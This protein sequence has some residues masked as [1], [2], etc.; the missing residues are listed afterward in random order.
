MKSGP[1]AKRLVWQGCYDQQWGGLITKDAYG[2]PAKFARGLIERIYDHCLERGWLQPGDVVGDPF[3]GVALGGIVAAYRKLRWLGVEIEPRFMGLADG[4]ECPGNRH[5]Q[6]WA[7]GAALPEWPVCHGCAADWKRG[8]ARAGH[9]AMGNLERHQDP[10]RVMGRAQPRQVMGDSRRFARIVGTMDLGGKHGR[11]PLELDG[12]TMS[13][14]Y[15]G[16][17]SALGVHNGIDYAKARQGGKKV[18]AGRRA[19]GEHYGAAKGQIGRLRTGRHVAGIVT[20]PP[21]EDQEGALAG[22]KFKF[23]PAVG[24]GHWTSPEARVAQLERGESQTYGK[25]PRQIGNER[26][27]T[28]WEAM[29]DVYGQC[30]VAMRMGGVICVVV[31]DY[32]KGGQVVPLCDSTARLLE[33]SGFTV[34]ERIRAMLVK[35][36]QVLNLDGSTDVDRT[37]RKGFF[38]RL[39]EKK[40][41]PAINWEEVI[42]ARKNY[43]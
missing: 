30:Q 39:A 3:G 14:P 12:V 27:E 32:V 1:R 8:E 11:F 33:V 17:G 34:V 23:V 29:A 42:I 5:V 2:H 36:T 28:Y 24:K 4:W 15:A 38:R 10:L 26:G 16:A 43:E 31:K 22:S 37:E 19:A 41:S 6:R 40:G 35:E 21:F 20:S 9:H 7:T 25:A 13:P 18:T